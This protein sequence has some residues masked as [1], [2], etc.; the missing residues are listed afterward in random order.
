MMLLQLVVFL[1]LTFT[2][3]WTVR[4][5]MGGSKRAVLFCLLAH[6]FFCGVPLAMDLLWGPPPY[7]VGPN[8]LRAAN[9]PAAQAIYL[10]FI[11]AVPVLLVL[12]GIS[13]K[14]VAA[15]TIQQQ[16]QNDPSADKPTM[17]SVAMLI[18]PLVLVILA[19]RPELYLMY[20]FVADERVRL[21]WDEQNYNAFL[22]LSAIMAVVASTGMLARFRSVA[23]PL[24]FTLPFI[25]LAV[26]VVGKR[27]V[28][29][30]YFALLTQQLWEKGVLRGARLP[31]YLV[32]V[33]ALFSIFTFSYQ[34]NIR[35]ISNAA[36]SR[37]GLYDNVRMDYGRDHTIRTAIYAE[38]RGDSIIGARG[39]SLA[40]YAGMYVPR[41]MWPD[42]PF[43]YASYFTCYALGIR[44]TLMPWGLT[45]SILDESIANFGWIGLLLGPLML[46]CLCR[47]A[48]SNRNSLFRTM[49]ILVCMLFMAVQL[50]AFM[51]L[52]LLWVAG[53]AWERFRGFLSLRPRLVRH[54]GDPA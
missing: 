6:Y 18:A 15:H 34:A 28:L 44:P 25:A 5:F 45:T 9:D 30:F 52:F 22:S 46:G 13:R 14:P 29:A 39:K 54:E 37:E 7:V 36:T 51:P 43:T 38:L 42:K 11:A 10:L 27:Y 35:G 17:I 47:I 31:L 50:P 53:S 26:W 12:T 49:G 32:L 23:K 48:D 40:F 2:V 16:L 33:A 19:P 3:T 4:R 41:S 21:T 1:W 8:L 20:A 24:I